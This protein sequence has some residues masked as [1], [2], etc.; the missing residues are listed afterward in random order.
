ML[1]NVVAA[2]P[3]GSIVVSATASSVGGTVVC[4]GC[5]AM[6]VCNTSTTLY[7][8]VRAGTGAQ[9]AVLTTDVVIPPMGCVILPVN[10]TTTNVAAIGSAGGPT[11]VG[12]SP[13]LRGQSV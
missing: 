1:S 2:V 5:D 4:T 9:T 13:I 7:V 3:G 10:D 11:I 6:R 12:F 8:A